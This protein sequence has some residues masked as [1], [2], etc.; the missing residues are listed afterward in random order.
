VTNIVGP[1]VGDRTMLA[2]FVLDRVA[3]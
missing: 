2:P 1:G 3:G